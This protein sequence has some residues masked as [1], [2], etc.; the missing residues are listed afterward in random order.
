MEAVS[1]AS[2]RG[3]HF[4][5]RAL[6]LKNTYIRYFLG[7]LGVCIFSVLIVLAC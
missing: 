6:D 1:D 3:T 5:T 4:P 2:Q 7:H